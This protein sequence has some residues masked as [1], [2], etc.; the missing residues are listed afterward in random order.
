MP[1]DFVDQIGALRL[2]FPLAERSLWSLNNKE[3]NAKV[4]GGK[5]MVADC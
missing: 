2:L 5:T 1:L 3:P 4:N